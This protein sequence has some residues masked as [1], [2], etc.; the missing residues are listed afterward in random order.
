ML[1]LDLGSEEAHAMCHLF[2]VTDFA[3]KRAL[4]GVH[5]VELRNGKYG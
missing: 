2:Y 3:D 5:R 1:A 4:E